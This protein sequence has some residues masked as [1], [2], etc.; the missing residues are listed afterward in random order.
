M[1]YVEADTKKVFINTT[2]E[3]VINVPFHMI[4]SFSEGLACVRLNGNY[5]YID[6]NGA[7]VIAIKFEQAQSFSEGL[8]AVLV[9]EKWGYIDNKG[10]MLI[11]PQFDY[12]QSFSEGLA[13][14]R[15]NKKFGYIDKNGTM[16]IKPE[17][18]GALDFKGLAYVTVGKK[19]IYIDS[20][21]KHIY[22]Y[23]K[24]GPVD[25]KK[26]QPLPLENIDIPTIKVDPK[27]WKNSIIWTGL[28]NNFFS[29]P[30]EFNI[31]GTADGRGGWKSIK[32][33]QARNQYLI[34]KP[35]LNGDIAVFCFSII[36]FSDSDPEAEMPVRDNGNF[37]DCKKL[38]VKLDN[39]GR[40]SFAFRLGATKHLFDGLAIRPD[41]NLVGSY[42]YR[43]NKGYSSS[44]R[45]PKGWRVTSKLKPN[46][47]VLLFEIVKYKNNY[48]VRFVP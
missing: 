8:A 32:K 11:K 47:E 19:L 10:N 26:D 45:I 4:S 13:A 16:V 6:R 25:A 5:G 9:D 20:T 35:N 15:I 36:A 42:L 38:S 30:T 48:A 17:F 12:A 43:T 34:P 40:N 24:S 29:P 7:I 22:E 33:I 28:E 23:A 27:I 2:G 3:V 37:I 31:I 1:A 18:D 46:T 41:G 44:I 14:V 39:E 21:G